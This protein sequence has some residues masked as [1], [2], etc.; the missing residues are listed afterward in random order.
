MFALWQDHRW[1]NEVWRLEFYKTDFTAEIAK[2]GFKYIKETN[3]VLQ[4]FGARHF[5]KV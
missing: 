4:G 1:N 5:V 3:P 2:R